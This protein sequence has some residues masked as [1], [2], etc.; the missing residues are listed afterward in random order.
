MNRDCKDPEAQR[1]SLTGLP[2]RKC[3]SMLLEKI[4][5][6]ALRDNSYEAVLCLDL[7][8][9]KELNDAVGYDTGDEI[10]RCV[11][12]RLGEFSEG[13]GR[14]CRLGGNEFLMHLHGAAG[15]AGTTALAR[16]VQTLFARPFQVEGLEIFL[17]ASIGVAVG[18]VHGHGS[19]V[20]I[21][22]AE[23]AMYR[24]K[25]KGGNGV[26]LYCLDIGSGISEKAAMEQALRRALK[27]Q[28]FTT[29]YQPLVE[30]DSC[31]IKGL[32]CLV[33]WVHPEW[34]IIPPGKF[35]G[36]AEETGL[37]IPIGEW[38]LRTACE[39]GV[40]WQTRR[41]ERIRIAVNIS[42]RQFQQESFT[43]D[44]EA[45]L[46]ETG[47]NPEN[48]EL[49]ITES[50][51]IQDPER[52]LD[53]LQRLRNLG[54]SLS[55]DD[56][57]TGYSSL[58][59]LKQ[60]PIQTLKIDRSFVCDLPGSS[61][62]EAIVRSILALAHGLDL[63]VVAEGVETEEQLEFLRA[64]ECDLVQGYFTGRPGP[65]EEIERLLV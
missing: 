43:A 5:M 21:H 10:I 6:Q 27:R 64:L 25:E 7:D 9:F 45:I 48:C 60:F 63:E 33:R 44:V 34:G 8:R 1:D 52:V 28:E 40:R 46:K 31:R 41:K 58:S 59:Y 62:D 19:Q 56:F 29:F 65:V 11:A 22:N 3:F 35:I 24:T 37:I 30:A 14:V 36:L 18:P 42:A 49:E 17:T 20:L 54:L 57:G 61:R 23:M 51:T 4:L 16:E 50:V 12:A 15:E 38:V 39:H 32:E 2:D 55:I 13:R 47:M 26:D 53:K